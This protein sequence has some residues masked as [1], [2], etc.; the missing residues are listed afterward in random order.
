MTPLPSAQRP[1]TAAE[2]QRADGIKAN[3]VKEGRAAERADW[4]KCLGVGSMAEAT[5]VAHLRKRPTLGELAS[6][7]H[8]S[9]GYAALFGAI[10]GAAV[11]VVVGALTL[12]Q[13]APA[14]NTVVHESVLTGAVTQQ[15]NPPQRCIGGEHLPDGRVCPQAQP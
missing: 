12:G 3:Y 11:A 7:R 1:L 5:E 13:Y 14:L 2:K 9:R 8:A 15:L 4:C 6:A 10:I